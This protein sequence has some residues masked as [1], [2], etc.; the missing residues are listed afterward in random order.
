MLEI[1]DDPNVTFGM[2]P[3]AVHFW[4]EHDCPDGT[5]HHDEYPP[6]LPPVMLERMIPRWRILDLNPETLT[7]DPNITCETCELNGYIR[8]GQWVPVEPPPPVEPIEPVVMDE[9]PLQ[10]DPEE[11]SEEP[12]EP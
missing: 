10:P 2:M 3:D 4:I 9:Y 1:L 11:E 12:E 7:V 6:N 8:S 5:R